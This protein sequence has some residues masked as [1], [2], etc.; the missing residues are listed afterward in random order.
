MRLCSANPLPGKRPICRQSLDAEGT[1][2][3]Y[4]PDCSKNVG[5][6]LSG[7][8]VHSMTAHS[9]SNLIQQGIGRDGMRQKTSITGN[10]VRP[11][12]AHLI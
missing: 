11:K 12:M 1:N 3:L 8:E 7:V 10:L 6:E 4:A 9:Q 5:W 2:P